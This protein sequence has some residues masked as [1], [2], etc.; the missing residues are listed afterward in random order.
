MLVGTRPYRRSRRN[1]RPLRG[2]YAREPNSLLLVRQPAARRSNQSLGHVQTPRHPSYYFLCQQLA[3]ADY[4]LPVAGPRT[5]V[6]PWH[7]FGEPPSYKRIPPR[8]RLTHVLSYQRFHLL[9]PLE[10]PPALQERRRKRSS[11]EKPCK[12]GRAMRHLGCF[13]SYNV[14]QFPISYT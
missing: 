6:P 10:C 11:T 3:S 7:F 9:R 14:G 5:Q 1:T 12:S 13:S 2:L 8:S 4:P